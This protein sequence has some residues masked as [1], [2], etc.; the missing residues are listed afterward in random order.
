VTR[1]L[2]GADS[3]KAV[4]RIVRDA[5]EMFG[6]ERYHTHRSDFSPAGFPDE[7]LVRP[8]RVVFA[9]L[10]ST[11]AW[12]SKGQGLSLE[13]L[14]WRTL[15]EACPGVEYHLWAPCHAEEIA[16]VLR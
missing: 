7:T 11:S 10:K 3:E 16:K 2:P 8:P 4:E 1:R 9:E 14:K 13:Q 12:R 6:W 5:A 15:L